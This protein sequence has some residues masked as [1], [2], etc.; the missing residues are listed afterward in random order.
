MGYS[1][2]SHAYLTTHYAAH[3][4]A[5]YDAA[6]DL[7]HGVC[8]DTESLADELAVADI[9]NDDQARL[10]CFAW[11]GRKRTR[12]RVDVC[13]CAP[14]CVGAC[15]SVRAR[16]Q[17]C[18]RVCTCVTFCTRPALCSLDVRMPRAPKRAPSMLSCPSPRA[19]GCKITSVL[20]HR[21]EGKDGARDNARD[22]S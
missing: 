1:E 2:Y 10:A 4:L 6:L 13:V 22:G 21:G 11:A 12:A 15:A 3:R 9:C 16:V 5:K 8:A 20:A 7:A 17:V 14:V 18:A 19:V